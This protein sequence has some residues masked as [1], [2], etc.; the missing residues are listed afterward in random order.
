MSP[1]CMGCKIG[2]E[3]IDANSS[4]VDS[5]VFGS[6]MQYLFSIRICS[7]LLCFFSLGFVDFVRNEHFG[8]SLAGDNQPRAATGY[9]PSHWLEE[10]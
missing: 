4:F 3:K 1:P 2:Q 6:P 5:I 9:H 7:H 10:E 8:N